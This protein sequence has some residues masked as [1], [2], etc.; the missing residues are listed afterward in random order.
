M[1]DADG[2]RTIFS[3]LFGTS[4]P[5]D[6]SLGEITLT[7]SYKFTKMLMGRA[8]LRQDWADKKVFALGNS[9]RADQAQTTIAF[10]MIYSF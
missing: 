6:V 10:Q 3:G 5:R 1:K 2:M 7:G 8:E 9:G 4:T